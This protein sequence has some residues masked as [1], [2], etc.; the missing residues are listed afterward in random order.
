MKGRETKVVP[1]NKDDRGVGR[2][3]PTVAS[4]AATDELERTILL[5]RA[6]KDSRAVYN[7]RWR[8]L[9]ENVLM[10]H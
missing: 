3:D 2:N 9:W 1:L 5:R 7:R 8:L 4:T 10:G 6:G